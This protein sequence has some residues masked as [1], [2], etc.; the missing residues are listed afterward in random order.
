MNRFPHRLSC[1]AEQIEQCLFKQYRIA[2]DHGLCLQIESD[3]NALLTDIGFHQGQ[4]G[5]DVLS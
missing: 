4:S 5:I 2:L 1:V 3:T